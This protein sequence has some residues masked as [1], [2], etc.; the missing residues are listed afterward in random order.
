MAL[1]LHDTEQN[2]ETLRI[3]MIHC[4]HVPDDVVCLLCLELWE[5]C[6][7]VM[8]LAEVQHPEVF[9]VPLVPEEE[10]YRTT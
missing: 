2:L 4:P 10:S 6:E 1:F 8:A 9:A 5:R 7:Q 3:A